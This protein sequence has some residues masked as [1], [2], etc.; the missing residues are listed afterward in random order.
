MKLFILKFNICMYTYGKVLFK[1]STFLLPI[2][3]EFSAIPACPR[4]ITEV[5]NLLSFEKL[6]RELESCASLCALK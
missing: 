5:L 4:S 3:S 2:L 1:N 6:K